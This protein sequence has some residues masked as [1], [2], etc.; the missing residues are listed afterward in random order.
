MLKVNSFATTDYRGQGKVF[1]IKRED[2][3]LHMY[4]IGKTGMG[5][6]ALLTNI[7]LNDIYAGEGLCFIDPHGQAVEQLLDYIPHSRVEDVIYF[8]PADLEYP[9]SMNVLE[10]VAPARRH[11]LVSGI[12]SIFRKLYAE[13]WQ[14][15]QEHILR[16]ALYTLLELENGATLIEMYHLLVDWR[17]RKSL[18]ANVQDPIIRA[19]WA[20]E[21]PKYVYQY[22][23]EA[24]A[25][26]QNKLGAFLTAPLIRNIVGQR[27]CSINFRSVIDEGKILLVNL[28]KGKLGEDNAAFLG[29]L[30]I[31]KLQLAALSRA[32]V[33]EDERRDFYLTVDEFQTFAASNAQGLD[34][35]LSEARKY[36]LSLTLAHQYIGQLD[37]RVRQ[38]I[39]GNVGTVISFAIGAEDADLLEREFLPAFNRGDLTGQGRYHIYIKLAIDGKTSPPF[40]AMTLS[41]FVHFIPQGTRQYIVERSRQQY[42]TALTEVV[43]EIG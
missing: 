9:I 18:V 34:D 36:R 20:H 19:F 22:K 12:I 1:G 7:A 16:N 40:S 43:K 25:P 24:L 17:Y 35:I 3:R 21:F 15:R 37:E 39:L 42:S 2:R 4:V 32:D 33:P 28:A 31:M 10:D 6:S 30:I 13:H 8:N 38:A 29:S 27:R 14:H 23:G 5:K 11:L 41:P 26:I